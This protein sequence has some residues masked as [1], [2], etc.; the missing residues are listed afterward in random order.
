MLLDGAPALLRAGHDVR[1]VGPRSDDLVP[2]DGMV[3]YGAGSPGTAVHSALDR[4]ATAVEFQS[5]HQ[6]VVDSS[7][8]I[9]GIS[10][11]RLQHKEEQESMA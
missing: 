6:E 5:F 11:Q 10:P 7:V 2:E 4:E 3:R 8:V 1:H 9:V